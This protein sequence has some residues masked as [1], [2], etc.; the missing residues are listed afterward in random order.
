MNAKYAFIYTIV[1]IFDSQLCFSVATTQSLTK[2]DETTTPSSLIGEVQTEE[3]EAADES[4][5]LGKETDNVEKK[6]NVLKRY[7]LRD[8]PMKQVINENEKTLKRLGNASKKGK[9]NEEMSIESTTSADSKTT[10][11]ASTDSSAKEEEDFPEVIT[12]CLNF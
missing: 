1:I 4:F 7:A 10:S 2:G 5:E 9:E 12:F 6:R 11:F 8:Q 3:I